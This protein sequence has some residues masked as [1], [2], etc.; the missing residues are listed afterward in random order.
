MSIVA[1]AATAADMGSRTFIKGTPYFLWMR[2]LRL[3]R[4]VAVVYRADGWSR[5]YEGATV[6]SAE[7]RARERARHTPTD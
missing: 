4:A 5:F 6:Y 3:G 1:K 2:G 7:D